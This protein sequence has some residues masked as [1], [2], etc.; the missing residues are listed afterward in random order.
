MRLS[1]FDYT[2]PEELIAQDP[3]PERDKSRLLVVDRNA[4]TIR[5]PAF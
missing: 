5:A 3:L 4:Q 1:D 2:L